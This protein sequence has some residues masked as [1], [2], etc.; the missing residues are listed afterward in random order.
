MEDAKCQVHLLNVDTASI[1]VQGDELSR[2]TTQVIRSE[3]V[4]HG[5]GK[6]HWPTRKKNV[7]TVEICVGL[8]RT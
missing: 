2:N 8:V 1:H 3:L 5:F 4:E 6:V 7:R